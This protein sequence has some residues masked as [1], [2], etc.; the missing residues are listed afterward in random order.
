MALDLGEVAYIAYSRIRN[1]ESIAGGNLMPTW[2][3]HRPEF[4]EAWRAAADAVRMVV[5][6]RLTS[7]LEYPEVSHPTDTPEQ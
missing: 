1:Y 2:S 5:E 6:G 3:E 7:P 4:R